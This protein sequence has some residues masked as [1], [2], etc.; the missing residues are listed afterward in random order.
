MENDERTK[1]ICRYFAEVNGVWQPA[2]SLPSPKEREGEAEEGK[3]R[4]SF[5]RGSRPCHPLCA[6]ANRGSAQA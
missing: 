5:Q 6:E 4:L 3:G 1:A 2:K